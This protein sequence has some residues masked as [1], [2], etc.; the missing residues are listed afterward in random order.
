MFDLVNGSSYGEPELYIFFYNAYE[1][2]K[3]A[4]LLLLFFFNSDTTWA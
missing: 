1:G 4:E 2:F 3:I